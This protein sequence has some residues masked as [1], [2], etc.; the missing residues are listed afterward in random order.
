[1]RQLHAGHSFHL[2]I[3]YQQVK[4]VALG[5]QLRFQVLRIGKGGDFVA[6]PI[7][8]KDLPAEGAESVQNCGIIVAYC[9]LIY[10]H[11]LPPLTLLYLFSIA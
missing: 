2:D 6:D 10:I 9:H 1:M 11:L 8:C 5:I 7:F 4:G 3:Q